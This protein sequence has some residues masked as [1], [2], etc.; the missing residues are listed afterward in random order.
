MKTES[1]IIFKQTDKMV[2]S[3]MSTEEIDVT[4]ELCLVQYIRST[5]KME[6]EKAPVCL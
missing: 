6:K 5:V 3:R 1:D 2:S 4:F